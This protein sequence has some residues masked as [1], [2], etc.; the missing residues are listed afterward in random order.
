MQYQHLLTCTCMWSF[1][2]HEVHKVDQTDAAHQI[3]SPCNGDVLYPKGVV[4]ELRK[5]LVLLTMTYI[6]FEYKCDLMEPRNF[7]AT[8][9][10]IIM[11]TVERFQFFIRHLFKSTCRDHTWSDMHQL[12]QII[13]HHFSELWVDDEIRLL[14]M[15]S[16]RF[17]LFSFHSSPVI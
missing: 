8:C 13:A 2:R 6:L 17:I 1:Q 16:T 4:H 9:A 11:L 7:L 12:Q 3:L 14:L 10:K 15:K 5:V